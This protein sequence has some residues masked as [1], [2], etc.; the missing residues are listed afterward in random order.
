MGIELE[1]LGRR[2]VAC[3]HWRWMPGMLAIMPEDRDGIARPERV[4]DDEWLPAMDS[5]PD[6]FDPA[7]FGCLLAL[8]REAWGCPIICVSHY[9]GKWWLDLLGDDAAYGLTVTDSI[10]SAL[11]TLD[12]AELEVAALVAALEAAP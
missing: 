12:A 8:V 3:K 6:L 1:A 9:A 5:F 4:L 2:A 7:T 11:A 10:V